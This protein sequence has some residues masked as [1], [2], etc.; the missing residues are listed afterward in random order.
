MTRNMG[1]AAVLHMEDRLRLGEIWACVESWA[2][3]MELT[4]EEKRR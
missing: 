2:T 4:T 3:K 1:E